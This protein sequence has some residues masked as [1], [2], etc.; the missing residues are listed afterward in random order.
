MVEDGGL[1]SSQAVVVMLVLER[2]GK[3]RD[4][5]HEWVLGGRGEKF[6]R[7]G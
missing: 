3:I 7:V 6:G 5:A 2:R 1:G 4:K